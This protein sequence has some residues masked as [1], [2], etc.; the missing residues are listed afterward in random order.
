MNK[1]LCTSQNTKAKTLSS[2]V[3]VFG[4]F[5]WLSPAGVHSA[6][7]RFDSEVKWW[8][9]VSS[10][11]RYVHKTP[12]RCVETVVNNALNR[13]LVVVFDR[14]W[15]NT[16]PTVTTAFSLTNVHDIFYSSAISRNF[17]SRS[18][19]TNFVEFF[20]VFRDNCRIWATWAFSLI[21]F[22]M[23][24]FKVHIAPLNRY[25]W[26]SRVRI[27]LIKPLLWLNGISPV[28]KQCFINTRN[29]DFSIVSKIC[30]CSLTV[31][32]KL[33]IQLGSNFNTCHLKVS[34]L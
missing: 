28:R 4:H 12:F 32:F 9:H 8:I 19:K 21:Y 1:I 26:W 29:S 34:T 31:F 10:I 30:N 27:T 18:A 5:E 3:C 24:A 20:G 2:D 17:N 6:D 11:V 14:L 23:T 33:I 16:A 13:W 22:C 25:F 15:A 7:C